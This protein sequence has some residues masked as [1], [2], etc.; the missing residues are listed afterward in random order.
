MD[1]NRENHGDTRPR[2]MARFW[3]VLFGL[4][5]ALSSLSCAQAYVLEGQ[6]WLSSPV[7]VSVSLSATSGRLGNRA[8][9]FPLSDGATSWESVISAASSTWNQYLSR[10]QLAPATGSDSTAVG[11]RNYRNEVFFGTMVAGYS[12][13]GNV[14]GL[15]VYWPDA[16]NAITE[17]DMA[18]NSGDYWNSYRGATRSSPIDLRRVAIHE[19]GHA[20]GLDH[21]DDYGQTVDAIMNSTIGNRDTLAADDIQGG[22]S[23]YG[24]RQTTFRNPDYDGD[25][26][27]DLLWRHAGNGT[28]SVWLMNG[29]SPKSIGA[30][31]A[32]P[33]AWSVIG[34]GDF[35]GDRRS[36][37]LLRN[38]GTGAISVLYM[39]GTTAKSYSGSLF[40]I[41]NIKAIG[42]FNGD[43][44]ADIV[45]NDPDLGT[46]EIRNWS[47]ASSFGTSYYGSV[48]RNW[49]VIGAIDTNGDGKSELLWR[50][51]QSG[52][53][54]LWTF[55]SGKPS[56]Y[57][58]WPTPSFLWQVRGIADIS[59]D[60]RQ[61]LVWYK[62]STG[63]VSVWNLSGATVV[64]T[65]MLV[66]AAKPWD[67]KTALNL[68]GSGPSEILWQIPS[69]G[70]LSYWSVS[71]SVVRG[72]Y[73]S[74]T[75]ST[76][77]VLQRDRP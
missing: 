74:P 71:N 46:L 45:S 14:I 37:I 64:R 25:G 50:N 12:L 15:T 19:L 42:D 73:L 70:R 21:P 59:G 22:Q 28:I 34:S 33:L 31:L 77:W 58:A 52:Q 7:P 40:G 11:S 65:Y 49:I 18:F 13:D 39:A 53:M 61:D 44:R 8:P 76:N 75:P 67:L 41:V 16:Q 29:S 38:A 51:R 68:N 43:Y 3:G 20:I 23:L 27:Q 17:F 66:R 10:V 62:P 60:G 63:D 30:P 69:T 2:D 54:S 9:T 72:Y 24:A 55:A 6:K 5:G 26:R 57:Y 48:S 32:A 36:D 56:G 4:C 47:G 1:T 35:D